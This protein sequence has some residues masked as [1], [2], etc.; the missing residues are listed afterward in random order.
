MSI[1]PDFSKMGEL[2][3]YKYLSRYL[4]L[5]LGYYATEYNY[6]SKNIVYHPITGKADSGIMAEGLERAKRAMEIINTI[7]IK[8]EDFI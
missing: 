1:Y 8:K 2:E 7:G 4:Y 5:S 6:D 3:K